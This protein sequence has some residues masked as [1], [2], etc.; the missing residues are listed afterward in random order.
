MD[1]YDRRLDYG[2]ADFDIPQRLTGSFTYNPPI[3]AAGFLGRAVNGWQLNGILSLYDG[4]PFS[5]QSASNTL[6]T[7][8]T[9]RASYVPGAGNGTLPSGQQSVEEWFNVAAFSAPGTLLYGD[10]G[11]NILRGP[12]THE[13]DISLFKN[14]QFHPD[15]SKKLQLRA[16]VFNIT[17]TP[18]FNNPVNTIGAAGAGSIT[19]AGSPYTL[20]RLSREIQLAAKFY[21]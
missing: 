12:G 1:T 4:L 17:N 13:M 3:R 10:A 5:V 8:G 18:Q 9:S 11:R 16:E 6:N 7:G 20:Q 21:F 2:N 14:F 15:S 19:S